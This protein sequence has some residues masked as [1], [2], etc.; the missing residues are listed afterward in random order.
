[1]LLRG[2][3]CVVGTAAFVAAIVPALAGAWAWERRDRAF[4]TLVALDERWSR[5]FVEL[6]DATLTFGSAPSEWER[7]GD[8]PRTRLLMETG[9][10]PG[11][12]VNEPYPDWRGWDRLVIP[13][14]NPSE[15]PLDV[16][17]RVDDEAHRGDRDDRYNGVF[18]L[19]AGAGLLKI[20]LA[21][22]RSAPAY[23]ELDLSAVRRIV[24]FTERPAVPRSL[25]LGDFRLERDAR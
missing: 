16:V 2:A 6:H 21:D 11:F 7:A 22:I 1:M 12:A 23:R 17:V 13:V 20:P 8:R 9:E 25:W 4:P 5:Q 19:G 15:R 14:Y 18:T 24:F 10:Y 3:A